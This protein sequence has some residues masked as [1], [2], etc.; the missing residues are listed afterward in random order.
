MMFVAVVFSRLQRRIPS[1]PEVQS[2]KRPAQLRAPMTNPAIDATETG[3]P[4]VNLRRDAPAVAFM[5]VLF[6]LSIGF[7]MAFSFTFVDQNVRAFSDP[8]SLLN[9]PI[10]PGIVVVFTVLILLIAKYGKRVLI[11]YIVLASVLMTVYYVAAPL[12]G[13]VMDRTGAPFGDRKSV[14]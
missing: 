6:L 8:Q 3:S 14:V 12:L 1:P 10:Y 2:H 13:T 9:A 5:A 7:A 11:K 4:G